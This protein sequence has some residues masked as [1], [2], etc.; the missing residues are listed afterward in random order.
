LFL[1]DKR[2]LPPA[3][4]QGR[5]V[6]FWPNYFAS[7]SRIFGDVRWQRDIRIRP[8]R[9]SF[10]VERR[11]HVASVMWARSQLRIVDL[12]VKPHLGRVTPTQITKTL[13]GAD[14]LGRSTGNCAGHK[15]NALRIVY[16]ANKDALGKDEVELRLRSAAVKFTYALRYHVTILHP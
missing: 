12:I 7:G 15:T 3:A 4:S 11:A 1:A 13:E 5:P 10:G 14:A 9:K 16:Q 6:R 8:Y 2:K